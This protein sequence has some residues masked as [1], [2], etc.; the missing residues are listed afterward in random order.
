MS[1]GIQTDLIARCPW[2]KGWVRVFRRD[3]RPDWI[4]PHLRPATSQV[5]PGAGKAP[6]GKVWDEADLADEVRA[7]RQ[8]RE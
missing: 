6:R 5:C 1:D 7:G 8:E 2:C 3:G 4:T